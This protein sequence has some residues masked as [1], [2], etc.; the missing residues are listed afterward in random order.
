M[1]L[2]LFGTDMFFME[3]KMV[4][5]ACLIM[6]AG[7]GSRMKSSIKKQFLELNGVPILALTI[8]KFDMCSE[9]NEIVVVAPKDDMPLC[10][11]I[12]KKYCKNTEFYVIEGGKERYNS[13][14]NGIKFL[15]GKCD[16]VMI[17]DGVRPFVTEKIIMDTLKAAEK[18]GACVPAVDVK[19]TIK[20]VDSECMVTNTLKRSTLRAVQTPQTFKYDLIK[21]AYENLPENADVTDD[22]SVVEIYGGKVKIIEG[23][24]DNIK[25]TTIEDLDSGKAI[26]KKESANEI[27]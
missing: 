8:S 25:I 1:C 4:K 23:S 14:Y 10:C 27:S 13:V 24:Y 26:L 12:C 11:E 17:Q 9:V 19:D 18:F 20:E 5:C 15:D 16:Y 2:C 22:A 7:K 21:N 3:V 6:A